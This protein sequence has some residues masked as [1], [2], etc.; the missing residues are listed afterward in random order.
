[1][2]ELEFGIHLKLGII[3]TNSKVTLVLSGMFIIQSTD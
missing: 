2:P 1:M 3:P